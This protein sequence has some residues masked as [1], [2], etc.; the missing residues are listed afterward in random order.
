M[1][2]IE[3]RR[4]VELQHK[5]GRAAAD[6]IAAAQHNEVVALDIVTEK[7][8]MLNRRQSPIVD[9]EIEDYLAHKPLN[10]RA[11]LDKQDAYAGAEFVVIATPTDYDPETN[12]FNTNSVEAVI[13]ER[14][15][16]LETEIARRM[17]ELSRASA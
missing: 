2:G 12:Y 11:T 10:F 16:N 1:I 5:D 13:R 8:D 9:H 7:V 14:V 3:P 4:V 17:A 15:T 6:Q